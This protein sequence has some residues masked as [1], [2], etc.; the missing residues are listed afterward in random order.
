MASPLEEEFRKLAR[1]AR[2]APDLQQQREAEAQKAR[3]KEGYLADFNRYGGKVSV[4]GSWDIHY[5]ND[6]AENARF[7][8]LVD[9]T[10]YTL[11]Q[12]ITY[13]IHTAKSNTDALDFSPADSS[14]PAQL[15]TFRLALWTLWGDDYRR[16]T[17]A[18]AVQANG[19]NVFHA[20][21]G[22]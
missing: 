12:L 8:G 9:G 4:S 20:G 13:A 16:M 21:P 19:I 10:R 14:R 6:S 3:T 1:Q 15:S 2:F 18:G 17:I 5:N 7:K 22:S 11:D